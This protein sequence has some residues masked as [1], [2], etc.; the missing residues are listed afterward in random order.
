MLLIV[1]FGL[2]LVPVPVAAHTSLLQT[3]PAPNSTLDHSPET[4]T[5][6]FDDPLQA[7]F[8]KVTVFDASQRPVTTSANPA[9]G[10]DPSALTIGV[11]KLKTGV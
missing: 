4:I 5:L 11:P 1:A 7:G 3:D 10:T 9:A 8:S 2:L 6:H